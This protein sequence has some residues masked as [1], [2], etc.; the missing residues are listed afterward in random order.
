MTTRHLDT[1]TGELL[2]S[3]TDHVATITLNNPAKRNA[4]SDN[5]TPAL[6]RML[7]E[8]EADTDVRVLVLTG[9]EGAF[10]AGGDVGGMG[11]TLTG[12]QAP[13]A[14]AM[15][16]RL[17]QAQETVSLKLHEFAK[18]TIAALPGAA[19]GAGMS[20]ALA[21]DMRIA[22]AAAFLAPAFGRIGLSGDFGGSWFLSR[23]I[24]PGRAK[25]IYF[26]SRRIDADEGAAL[27]IFNRVVPDDQLM[28]ATAGFAAELAAGPPIAL[29]YMK[30]NI[31]R[32]ATADLRTALTMEA[33]RMIRTMLSDDHKGAARAFLEKRAPT[34][35][36]T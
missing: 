22:G 7:V 23:L 28:Q 2:C 11:D 31:N 18:P 35:T 9:A 13:D 15:I 14:D 34:F 1:G 19:A 32:A 5:L 3:V 30:E 17:R 29:R 4:L 36:G 24:G 21:C 25:E 27:G 33:D 6:R 10:C 20:I 16:A 26:S 12:G 8:T